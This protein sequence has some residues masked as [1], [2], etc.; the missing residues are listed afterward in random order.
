MECV[1]T[2][3]EA[4]KIQW[5]RGVKVM[6]YVDKTMRCFIQDRAI[7]SVITR[8]DHNNRSEAQIYNFTFQNINKSIWKYASTRA[9]I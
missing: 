4:I 7:H 8:F 9:I 3:K 1:S 6:I 5:W 2:A